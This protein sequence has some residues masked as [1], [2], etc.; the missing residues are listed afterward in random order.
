MNSSFNDVE[1]DIAADGL[2]L[3]FQSD[4]PGGFGGS[5]IYIATRPNTSAPFGAVANL[6]STVNSSSFEGRRSLSATVEHVLRHQPRRGRERDICR[7]RASLI[8]SS[9]NAVNLGPN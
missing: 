4:C 2:A 5:D 1:P 8:G 7:T 9:D 6:G 3:L